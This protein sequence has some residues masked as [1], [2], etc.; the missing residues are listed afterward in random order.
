MRWSSR[1]MVRAGSLSVAAAGAAQGLLGY[2][3]NLQ[4]L[5]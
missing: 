3:V 2:G 5:G 1:R 4:D